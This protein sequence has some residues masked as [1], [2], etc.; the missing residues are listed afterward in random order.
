MEAQITYG[1]TIHHDG[2]I[3]KFEGWTFETE[4]EFWN[5]YDLI[6]ENNSKKYTISAEVDGFS[7]SRTEWIKVSQYREE[8]K[9][10]G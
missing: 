7:I 4:E 1:T 5:Q 2:T 3:A 8:V 6:M 9:I 10:N